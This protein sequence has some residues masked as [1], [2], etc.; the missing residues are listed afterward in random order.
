MQECPLYAEAELYDRLFP[1]ARNSLS[2][3]DPAWRDRIVASEQFY[4]EEAKQS[5]G[6]VLELACG[7]GRLT[8]PIAQSEVDITGLDFSDSMLDAARAKASA[9]LAPVQFVRGDMR[10]FVLPERF[11]TIMIASNSLLHLLTVEDLTQCFRSVRRHLE[12]GG[13]LIFDIF[14]PDLRLLARDPG[15]R[16]SLLHMDDPNGGEINLEETAHYDTAT[17]IRYI[18]WH[19][20]APNTPDFRVI[21]YHLR[22]I[23]PQ[24]LLVLLEVAGLRLDKRFGDF[25]RPSFESSSPR[26]VCFCSAIP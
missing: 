7:S 12:P 11:A 9:A 22:V 21:D 2:I 5:R 13:R 4:L 24:E 20:S 1:Q 17:Q 15:Q 23:F 18:R 16:Y 14:N 6:R 8:V 3:S 19:F 10:N 25:S 26:Q